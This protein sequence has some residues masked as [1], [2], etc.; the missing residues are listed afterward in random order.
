MKD[1]VAETQQDAVPM[2]V[3][4]VR[5][6]KCSRPDATMSNASNTT[7]CLSPLNQEVH[8]KFGLVDDLM[9]SAHEMTETQLTVDGPRS[10]GKDWRGG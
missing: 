2:Y 3:M 9:T 10:D 7:N 5:R 1:Q 4:S 8:E 6:L